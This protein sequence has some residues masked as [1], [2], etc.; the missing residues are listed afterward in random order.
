[1]CLY[2]TILFASMKKNGIKYYLVSKTKSTSQLSKQNVII[3]II[4][5]LL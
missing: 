3:T 2:F 5:K 4:I 1:M